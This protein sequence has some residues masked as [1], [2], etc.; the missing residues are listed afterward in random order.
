MSAFVV[1]R[2]HIRY[3]VN[4][5]LVLSRRYGLRWSWGENGE[6]GA[7]LKPGM[8]A[9]AVK[10]GAMLWDECRRSVGWRYPQ[11][12]A[13]PGSLGEPEKFTNK[14]IKCI[15]NVSG[16]QL[17]KSC[18]CYEYQSCEHPEWPKSEA[19][20]FLEVL[21]KRAWTALPGYEDAEWGPP[22]PDPRVLREV[23]A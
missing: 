13:L 15:G 2:E 10:L 4:A 16:V 20:A 22:K 11:D 3:L 18:D 21:R 23:F 14:D 1:S 17:L 9:E 19:R 7:E 6:Y 8:H 12:S 5:G